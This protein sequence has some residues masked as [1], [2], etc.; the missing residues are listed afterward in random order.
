[1][2]AG[3]LDDINEAFARIVADDTIAARKIEI[4]F[5]KDR[6]S[7]GPNAY[8]LM[9]WDSS[10][11]LH[12]GGDALMGF[13]PYCPASIMSRVDPVDNSMPTVHFCPKCKRPFKAEKMVDYIVHKT[14]T[15]VLADKLVGLWTALKGDADIYLKFHK[16]DIRYAPLDYDR[17][18][19]LQARQQR[20]PSIYTLKRILDDT[21]G[22]AD[23]RARFL[24]FLRA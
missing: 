15:Q 21:T 8:A 19:L 10:G 7:N 14:T 18:K 22:G 6:T 24:A 16:K 9:V 5:G 2:E 1:M 11:K 4:V 20:Y 13:C 3:R 23:L 12:G 17:K